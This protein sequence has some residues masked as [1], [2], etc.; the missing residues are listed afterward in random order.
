MIKLIYKNNKRRIIYVML[1]LISIK[2]QYL[3]IN[4]LF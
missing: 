2:T 4:T 3:V 1:N